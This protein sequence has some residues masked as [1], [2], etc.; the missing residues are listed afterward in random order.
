MKKIWIGTSWKM[1]KD[2]QSAEAWASAVSSSLHK[3]SKDIQPFVIPPFPYIEPVNQIF[4]ESVMKIGAQNMCWE[5]QGAY[6]G[7]VSPTMLKDCGAELVE[8]GHSE[9]R[10]MFGETDHCVNLKVLSALKHGLVPL[11]CI[12][13]TLQEKEW[14]V[15]T[16]S[17]IRQVK[18]A[19]YKVALDQI[20]RVIFAYEPV[21]AIGENGRPAS[22]EEAEVIHQEIRNM[23]VNCYGKN[24]AEKCVLLYGGSVNAK[25]TQLLL[26]QP[27]IDGVFVGRSAWKE[28][29]F[30]QLLDIADKTKST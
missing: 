2:L 13:D 14:G 20:E 6:T 18:I 5:L 21:W 12:G 8:I 16:E 22:P 17:V 19:L 11:V 28:E 3:Y 30:I 9:R 29:D 26:E 4:K 15:S 10:A 23:L 27:N 24:V 7:E 25:N 1:N